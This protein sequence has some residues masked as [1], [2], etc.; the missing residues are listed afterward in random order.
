VPTPPDTTPDHP[1]LRALEERLEQAWPAD[2]PRLRARLR[3][4]TR[5]RPE[6]TRRRRRSAPAPDTAPDPKVLT[7][8]ER[9]LDESA[10]RWARRR[11][12]LPERIAYPGDLPI[13]GARDD[14][15]HAIRTN[16][17]VVLCGETGSGKTTQLPKICLELGYGIDRRIAHTQ[18]RRIAATA[19]ARRVAE[20]L[21]VPY[22]KQVGAKV[23]FDDKTGDDTLVKLM[24]DGMLLA[25]TQTDRNLNQ[26]D[27]II[28]DEAHERSLN[29]DFLLGYLRQLLPR[30]PDLKVIITSAT[31]DP[32]RFAEHFGAFNREAGHEIPAPIITVPGRTYPVQTRY[33]PLLDDDRSMDARREAEA[34]GDGVLT[35]LA[36]LAHEHPQGDVLVFMPGEREIRQTAKFL[37]EN[38]PPTDNTEI[39][40]LYARLSPKEQERVFR[41]AP[42][43]RVVIATNVA[44]TSLTVPG[45][46]AVIDPGTARISRYSARSKVQGLPTE[47]IS[48]ASADQRKGR[49]GRIGPGTCIRLFSEEDLEGRDEFTPPEIL[50]TN[51]AAVVLQMEAL[52]LG[53]PED[54]PFIDPPDT[55]LIKDGYQTLEELG[56]IYPRDTKPHHKKPRKTNLTPLGEKLAR[57]PVDP[58]LG[59][60]ILAGQEENCLHDLLVIASALAAPDPRDRPSDKQQSADEAHE[61]FAHP[62]S[63][64]LSYLKIWDFFHEQRSKLSRSRLDK[65]CRQNFLSLRRIHEWREIHRQLHGIVLDMGYRP[66]EQRHD[67]DSDHAPYDAIHRALLAGLITNVGRQGEGHEYKGC[68][69]T[70][71]FIHP[72]S[73]LFGD[74]PQWLLAGELVRT[75]RLYARTVAK[76]VPD[77]IE[78][79]AP[80]MLVKSYA[81]ARYDQRTA[82]VVANEK[83]SLEGLEVIP[84]R[85]V[86]FGPIDPAT[87]R[88]LF[89]H[90]ALVEG[91]LDTRSKALKHNRALIDRIE[92]MQA[93]ARRTDLLASNK[94]QFDFYDARLPE[95]V[96]SGSTFHSWTRRAERDDPD[97]LRMTEDD[98]L[99]HEPE[100]VTTETYPDQYQTLSAPLPLEYVFDPASEADG[101]TLTVPVELLGQIRPE[102]ADRLVPGLLPHKIAALVKTLPK[103][104]RRNFEPREIADK[105]TPSLQGSDRPLVQDLAEALSRECGSRIEV[106]DL[107]PGELDRHLNL[108]YRV[109]D[110]GGEELAASRDLAE[111]RAQ[112]ADRITGSVMASAPGELDRSDLTDWDF[113]ELPESIEIDRAGVSVTAFPALVDKG[114]T[115]DL[116]L[117]DT[118]PAADAAMRAGLG[119]LY[120]RH[121][122]DEFR[123]RIEHLPGIGR[124]RL[125][126]AP[127]GPAGELDRD[128]MLLIAD[129]V[130]VNDRVNVRSRE[131]FVE[132]IDAG[133]NRLTQC[134][135]EAADLVSEILTR[136]QQ[137]DELLNNANPPQQWKLAVADCTTQLAVMCPPGFLASTPYRWL[138]CFPRFLAGIQKRFEK[139]RTHG[140]DRDRQHTAQ[141]HE[142]TRKYDQ[143]SQEHRAQGIVDPE[144][145]EFRWLTEELRVSLFA[146]ELGTSVKVSPARLQKHWDKIR[147]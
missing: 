19:V 75:T 37:R 127:L 13:S 68:R 114:E 135:N 146:Q 125:L 79:V 11:D 28:I 40:P 77:W 76:I 35:A 86:H 7:Q 53:S 115:C 6:G 94:A 25:E 1:R 60:M 88:E 50:R 12:L 33:R 137:C 117:F 10:D 140:P 93:K 119:R 5:P 21:K 82:T 91:E 141:V 38:L 81:E 107:K 133:W 46:R 49:C 9:D 84:K 132:R 52:R 62:E 22:G 104:L 42:H 24:T 70:T 15:A 31:I 26:Y 126:Y 98:L 78:R 73:G 108:R 83:V 97:L 34:L 29:I 100:H 27:C 30:R 89:I 71:F 63:D 92:A 129:R 23:R 4:L 61:Q 43:R 14:I 145:E 130:F 65:A 142:W 74:K 144:L 134:T 67:K 118:R 44:E 116:K 95:D 18:P 3:G 66:H 36:E 72:G 96:Y 102:T 55:R 16:Q 80:H 138:R 101:V 59:R 48:R 99:V 20:E 54:F 121:L 105:L 90:H 56:A 131:Q 123:V 136:R 122:R 112:F 64:F 128:L 110:D 8:I 103:R 41:T 45:I 32:D 51:L 87:S 57:L 147:V 69:G 113:G 120:V 139:L 124:L 17:V 106:G 58:R 109:I 143:R 47:P 85:T 39:L 2:R 111:L